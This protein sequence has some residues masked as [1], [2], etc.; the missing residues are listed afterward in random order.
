MVYLPRRENP[1]EAITGFL[2][3]AVRGS[4]LHTTNTG[5][6]AWRIIFLN[7]AVPQKMAPSH[8]EFHRDDDQ[9]GCFTS[10]GIGDLQNAR[11]YSITADL[12]EAESNLSPQSS[13]LFPAILVGSTTES[14]GAST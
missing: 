11:Y 7:R 5:Q 12:R 4:L 13:L 1:G 10:G 8:V 14:L 6:G 2:F 9:I 3:H